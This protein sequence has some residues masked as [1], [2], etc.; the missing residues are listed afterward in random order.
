MI[1]QTNAI[2]QGPRTDHG[3]VGKMMAHLL[4]GGAAEAFVI[5]YRKTGDPFVNNLRVWASPPGSPAFYVARLREVDLP[6]TLCTLD[7]V[8]LHQGPLFDEP[9]GASTDG[10]RTPD[11]LHCDGASDQL[12]LRSDAGD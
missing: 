5:N 8:G 1:G 11:T 4:E 2:L 9:A 6:T 10:S 12:D 7:R 3:T